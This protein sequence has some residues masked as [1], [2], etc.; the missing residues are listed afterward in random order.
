M[1]IK[2]S[3]DSEFHQDGVNARSVVSYDFSSNTVDFNVNK[4]IAR[5]FIEVISYV[6]YDAGGNR[7][8]RKRMRCGNVKVR[9]NI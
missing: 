4:M 7:V 9:I 6:V 5:C 3:N 2:H 1:L 8:F